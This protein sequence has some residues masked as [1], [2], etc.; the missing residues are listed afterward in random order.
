MNPQGSGCQIGSAARVKQRLGKFCLTC[1]RSCNLSSEDKHCGAL[2]HPYMCLFPSGGAQCLNFPVRSQLCQT[3]I[4]RLCL[5]LPCLAWMEVAKACVCMC[6]AC[7]QNY[8]VFGPEAV[9]PFRLFLLTKSRRNH[10]K[11]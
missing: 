2:A 11:W 1:R 10:Y 5:Q 6:K 8:K 3:L 4:E 9:A 7:K